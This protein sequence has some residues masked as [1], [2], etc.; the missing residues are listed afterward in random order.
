M[1]WALFVAISDAVG[2]AP[3]PRLTYL[4]GTLDIMRPGFSHEQIKT[5]LAHLI[6]AWADERQIDLLGYGNAT[7]RS[8][9]SKRG[10]EPDEWYALHDVEAEGRL[11]DLAI[12]IIE[13]HGSID[14]LAV[15]AGLGVPEVWF[16]EQGRI[17]IYWLDDGEYAQKSASRLLPDLDIEELAGFVFRGNQAQ[18]VRAYRAHLRSKGSAEA[19]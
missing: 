14:K 17:A 7:F 9:A 4:E 2:D 10:A 6:E 19:P 12:E 11:P 15:Y 5:T 8:E 3:V 18:A 16:W 13:T 1:S